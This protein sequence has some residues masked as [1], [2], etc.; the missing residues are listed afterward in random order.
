MLTE[1]KEAAASTT[2]RKKD[3]LTKSYQNSAS[4]STVKL[5]VGELLL[6]LQTPLEQERR[7]EYWQSFELKL[8][9]YLDLKKGGCRCG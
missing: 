8:R 9:Q 6:R 3:H 5:Q 1:K 4:E 2:A 7:K